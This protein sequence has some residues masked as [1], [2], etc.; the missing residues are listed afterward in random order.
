[1]KTIISTTNAPQAIGP[2]SQGVDTGNLVF[3]SGQLPIVPSEGKIVASD[4]EGQTKQSL[5]NIKAIL[6]ADGCTMDDVLKTTVYLNDIADFAKMNEV[7]K[8]FFKEGSYPARSAFQVAA[9]PQGALVEIE[10]VA[11]KK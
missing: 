9:L 6:E 1:M 8:G 2:Y 4:I 7:Y 3:L 11:L 10:V 5:E